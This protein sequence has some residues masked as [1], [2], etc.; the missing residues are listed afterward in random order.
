[1]K[2][3]G[4]LFNFQRRSSSTSLRSLTRNTFVIFFRID[5]ALISYEEQIF[6]DQNRFS[7]IQT[8]TAKS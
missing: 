8:Q 4:D 2:G 7:I 3:N 6:V 5:W 1:M